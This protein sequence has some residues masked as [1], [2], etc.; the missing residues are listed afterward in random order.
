MPCVQGAT[1]GICEDIGNIAQPN[2]VLQ[3]RNIRSGC[4]EASIFHL[5]SVM[6][7]GSYTL[8]TK[9]AFGAGAP[10]GHLRFRRPV[11][12]WRRAFTPGFAPLSG[13]RKK[14]R[15]ALATFVMGFQEWRAISK[16]RSSERMAIVQ[17]ATNITR[18]KS[19]K[20]ASHAATF[21]FHTDSGLLITSRRPAPQSIID[22]V[23][24]GDEV[25]VYYDPDNPRNFVFESESAPW[26][27]WVV[28]TFF[29]LVGL[30]IL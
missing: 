17:S 9:A 3:T 15:V 23:R 28:G 29:V 4:N 27:F 11:K 20:L 12:I 26:Q 13:F 2:T 14:Y 6:F 1:L 8:C 22:A 16:I 24:Q 19:K 25:K 30:F 7:S 18:Q 5:M 10:H 21:S